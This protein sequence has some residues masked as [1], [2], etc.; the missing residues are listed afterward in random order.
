MPEM[1][2]TLTSP[3]AATRARAEMEEVYLWATEVLMGH[4]AAEVRRL[5]YAALEAPTLLAAGPDPF[6]YTN[7]RAAWYAAVRTMTESVWGPG[8][9]PKGSRPPVT[10][11]DVEALAAELQQ[12]NFP[13]DLFTETRNLLVRS[14]NLQWGAW[15]TKRELS[16]L[17]IPKEGDEGHEAYKNR[18]RRMARTAATRNFNSQQL[19]DLA[20]LGYSHKKWVARMDAL[21]RPDHLGAN[22]EV[23][24]LSESFSVG[25]ESMMHPGD[26]QGSHAQTANCRCT[27]IGH[28]E[29]VAGPGGGPPISPDE[30][31]ALRNFQEA[32]PELWYD[33]RAQE[34][35]LAIR[36]R[37][38]WRKKSPAHEALAQVVAAWTGPGNSMQAVRDEIA[39]G[40]HA[41]AL[42]T[43]RTTP[44]PKD[45]TLYRGTGAWNRD[46]V[47]FFGSVKPGDTIEMRGIGSFTERRDWAETF[48]ETRSHMLIKVTDG[49]G[50]PVARISNTPHEKEWLLTG[51][52]KVTNVKRTAKPA[53]PGQAWDTDYDVEV[54]AVWER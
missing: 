42:K 22:G 2:G 18:V 10:K 23:V 32:D 53:V 15:R 28:G 24:A 51:K 39:R 37:E 30:T 7:V 25:G 14:R 40:E 49:Y 16:K 13:D 43:I 33:V 36:E 4:F 17:L 6:A 52:L 12:A 20:S 19:K 5:A 3:G 45:V 11:I 34:R 47:A 29:P 44:I 46:R 54:E 21:T 9:A 26:P 48:G 31:S 35:L 27:L 8:W 38:S 1:T 50:V 41:L